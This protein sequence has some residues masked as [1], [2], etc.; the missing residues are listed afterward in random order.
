V[1]LENRV[2]RRLPVFCNPLKVFALI[3]KVCI[4]RQ[5]NC[6]MSWKGSCLAWLA[7]AFTKCYSEPTEGPKIWRGLIQDPLNMIHRY[8][9]NF[10]TLYLRL[11]SKYLS[12]NSNH[13]T[14]GTWQ[15]DQQQLCREYIKDFKTST[16]HHLVLVY[17]LK[18]PS[19]D[20]G[21]NHRTRLCTQIDQKLAQYWWLLIQYFCKN[22]GG[23]LILF[24]LPAL[25]VS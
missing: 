4:L 12:S 16:G 24:L 2:S 22:I 6:S 25:T 20:F 13:R 19:T 3:H 14:H 1:L 9:A 17:V 23:Y 10:S 15:I 7:V 5:V 11:K 21:E 18:F 8:L